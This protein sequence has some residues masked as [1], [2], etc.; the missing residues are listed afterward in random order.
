MPEEGLD[1]PYIHLPL[2][3]L[4][5]QQAEVPPFSGSGEGKG[6]PWIPGRARDDDEEVTAWVPGRARDDEVGESSRTEPCSSSSRTKRSGDPGSIP[7]PFPLPIWQATKEPATT[8][9]LWQK[10]DRGERYTSRLEMHR[11]LSGLLLKIDCEGKGSFAYQ[12]EGIGICWEEGGT[13]PEHYFQTLGAA[14]WLELQGVPCIHANALDTGEGAIGI[15]A[16]S[17]TGK[18]TLTAALLEHGPRLMTDDMLALHHANGQWLVHPG[19][20]LLRMWPDTARQYLQSGFEALPRVH[21]RFDKRIVHLARHGR[22]AHGNQ[23]RPL[24][25]LYLLERRK[26][27]KGEIETT[28][29]PPGEA[30]LHLL[31]NSMLADAYRPLGL[32]QPRLRTLATLL[33][34]IP[35]TRIRYPSGLHHLSA[36]C[37][38]ITDAR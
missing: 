16:P 4:R 14:L 25:R 38:R 19:W 34:E 23:A 31:Q 27:N 11:T 22:F 37:Q 8:R 17:R 5:L 30:L 6:N 28:D 10:E 33:E 20:P 21:G 32:E 24:R 3:G 12:P 13:G 26:E 36:V 9:L 1:W 2:H 15:I 7:T 35:L 29:I 18:T